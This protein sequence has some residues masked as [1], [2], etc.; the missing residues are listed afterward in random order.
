MGR[1][2]RKKIV[3]RPV[4]RVPKIFTCPKCGHKTMKAN[5]KYADDK[6]MIICGH[7]DEQQEVSRNELTE[8]VDAFGS[9]IDIYY[10][11]QEY[12][13]LTRREEKLKEKQQYTELTLVYSFLADNA[14]INADK[15]LEEFEKFR[16]PKDLETAERWKDASKAYKENEKRLLEQLKAGLIEDAELEEDV[17]GDQE[18]NPFGEEQE[19]TEKPRRRADIEEILGDTGFLEF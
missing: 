2:K 6:V 19:E 9:F 17:Y 1:R 18:I 8:P 12:E 10:K 14:Q 11:D 4:R 15:A 16:D 3:Y 7:C 5:M 13:R